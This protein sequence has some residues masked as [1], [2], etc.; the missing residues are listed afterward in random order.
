MRSA[1]VPVLLLTNALM[2]QDALS[3]KYLNI[4]KFK[5]TTLDSIR[6]GDLLS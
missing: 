1:S 5:I 3:N 6:E 2:K 4:C